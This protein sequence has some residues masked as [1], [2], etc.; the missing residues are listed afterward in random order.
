MKGSQNGIYFSKAGWTLTCSNFY[1]A[2][3][4]LVSPLT[5][6]MTH[7]SVTARSLKSIVFN[8]LGWLVSSL[9]LGI[10]H[11]FTEPCPYDRHVLVMGKLK[12]E[13]S[14]YTAEP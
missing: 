6:S 4:L 8:G 7:K 10:H 9:S 2:Q 12:K 3:K 5:D 13:A 14:R 11:S 1:F